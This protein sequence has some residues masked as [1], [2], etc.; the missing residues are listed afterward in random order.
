MPMPQSG[1]VTQ[2]AVEVI[3]GRISDAISL[4]TWKSWIPYAGTRAK[5]PKRRYNV[6]VGSLPL[7]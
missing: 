7:S 6:V 3:E 2:I 4:L 5:L 1:G